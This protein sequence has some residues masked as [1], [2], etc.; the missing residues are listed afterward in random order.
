MRLRA[1]MVGV[2][3]VCRSACMSVGLSIC[4]SFRSVCLS[5]LPLCLSVPAHLLSLFVCLYVCSRE[6]LVCLSVG[7]PICLSAGLSVC[8][9]ALLVCQSLRLWVLSCVCVHRLAVGAR[10]GAVRRGYGRRHALAGP[11][12]LACFEEL[13]LNPIV[14]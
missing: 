2:L 4:L 5:V 1:N 14:Y 12:I 11:V 9:S 13:I 3:F 6:S 7:R 10:A 8:L